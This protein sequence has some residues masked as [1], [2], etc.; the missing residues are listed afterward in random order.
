[1]FSKWFSDEEIPVNH[2]LGKKHIKLL[3]KNTALGCGFEHASFTLRNS[4]VLNTSD[5][6]KLAK[7]FLL[8]F[9]EAFSL[10]VPLIMYVVAYLKKKK[11]KKRNLSISLQLV[12]RKLTVYSGNCFPKFCFV[13]IWRLLTRNS[14]TSKQGLSNT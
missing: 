9:E 2:H 1:M 3:C 7:R 13:P 11:K 14:F 5:V 8:S 12:I 4:A 10:P 6:G